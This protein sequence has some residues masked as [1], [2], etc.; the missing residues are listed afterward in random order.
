MS[1]RAFLHLVL[2]VLPCL[3]TRLYQTCTMDD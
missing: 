2:L 1:H 3:D